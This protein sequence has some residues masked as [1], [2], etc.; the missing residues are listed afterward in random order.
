MFNVIILSSGLSTRLKPI[1]NEIPKLLVNVGK[2]TALLRQ[3]KFWKQYKDLNTIYVVIHPKYIALVEAY[4]EMNKLEGIEIIGE[5]ESKGSFKAIR[6]AVKYHPE[7]SSNVF[8]NWSD[9]IPISL[10]WPNLSW[11]ESFTKRAEIREGESYVY[12]YGNNHRYNINKEDEIHNVGSGGNVP[13]LYYVN[14]MPNFNNAKDGDDFI[15][16]IIG[17]GY[18]QLPCALIDFGDMAKLVKAESEEQVSREF[19][20]VLIGD[21]VVIKKAMNSKGKE[22]Q[23]KELRWYSKNPPNTPKILESDEFSFTMMKASGQPLYKVYEDGL[24]HKALNAL[25]ALHDTNHQKVNQKIVQRDI[26]KEV[27]EKTYE[28]KAAIQPLLDSFGKIESVNGKR[29][30]DFDEMCTILYDRL[31]WFNRSRGKYAFIHGDPNFSN[32]MWDGRKISFIDPRG[33]FGETKLYGPETYDQAKVLYALSGYDNFNADSN[34][35]YEI[36]GDING[37]PGTNLKLNIPALTSIKNLD[38]RTNKTFNEEVYH[39]LALIWVNLGG[40]F[41]N[42]PL[43][44]VLAYYYGLH[45]ATWCIEDIFPKKRNGYNELYQPIDLVIHTKVPFKWFL[46]DDEKDKNY[47]GQSDGPNM[48]WKKV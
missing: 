18:K 28:R 14:E 29:L 46:Y 10:D 31:S 25:A 13:G 35:T 30:I 37:L 41:K 12:T 44:A 24:E 40:Y 8:L 39:W 33:Y 21:D 45:L 34:F 7:L 15:D 32:T 17:K 43:K 38:P 1:T 42:N 27:V 11:D 20:D 36:D 19:N 9:L 16:H 2:E 3:Y 5:P 48:M 22:L 23:A 26:K 4:I 47:I 6:N